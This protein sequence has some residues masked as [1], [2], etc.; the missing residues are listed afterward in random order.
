MNSLD[1]NFVVHVFGFD[2]HILADSEL[3]NTRTYTLFAPAS[4]DLSCLNLSDLVSENFKDARVATVSISPPN[5]M[6]LAHSRRVVFPTS[7]L[8]ILNN[9]LSDVVGKID[10]RKI[11]EWCLDASNHGFFHL[12]VTLSLEIGQGNGLVLGDSFDQLLQT[13]VANREK[14][15]YTLNRKALDVVVDCSW[16]G[17]NETGAQTLIS[18]FIKSLTD[19]PDIRQLFLVNLPNSLPSYCLERID[20]SRVIIGNPDTSAEVD[21]FWRPCQPDMFFDMAEA[22]KCAKRVVITYFDLIA[23][24]ISAYHSSLNEW[25]QYRDIQVKNGELSDLVIAISDDV[26]TQLCQ[27]IPTINPSRIRKVGVGVDHI[28]SEVSLKE[29]KVSDSVRSLTEDKYVLFLGTNY[30]HK[31]LNFARKVVDKAFLEGDRPNLVIAGL[32]PSIGNSDACSGDQISEFWLGS[33]DTSD[34]NHLLANAELV[35]YPTSAEGFGLV[36]FEAASFGTP[37]LFTNFGPLGESFKSKDL[38]DDWDLDSYVKSLH[39]LMSKDDPFRNQLI[40]EVN[41][42]ANGRLSWES[43]TEELIGSFLYALESPSVYIDKSSLIEIQ[44]SLSWKITKPLRTIGRMVRR[45]KN[46]RRTEALRK[47]SV[48]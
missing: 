4:L 27:S 42:L 36:P 15:F 17:D 26:R 10:R 34:R 18:Y 23:F 44:D 37:T 47:I 14:D 5:Q 40:S 22:R 19:H 7:N 25:K 12:E 28:F 35:I 21:I 43:V 29:S 11:S 2:G 39:K 13:E 24:D 20:P 30:L 41:S 6:N 31:N 1:D 46:Q 38:P 48:N 3:P 8:M 45:M 9:S 16:L 32:D 33:V